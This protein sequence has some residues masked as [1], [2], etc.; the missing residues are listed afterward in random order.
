ME[1]V[2]FVPAIK[3]RVSQKHSSIM[4][5][6]YTQLRMTHSSIVTRLSPRA[7]PALGYHPHARMRPLATLHDSADGL[8][9]DACAEPRR[10]EDEAGDDDEGGGG[11]LAVARAT[12]KAGGDRGEKAIGRRG[13]H[14]LGCKARASRKP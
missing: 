9:G 1:T 6:Y 12:G 4:A 10:G 13:Q 11:A 14:G 3:K 7:R 5:F 2:V 8:G